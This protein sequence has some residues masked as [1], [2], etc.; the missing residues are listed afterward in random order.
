MNIQDEIQKTVGLLTDNT[1]KNNLFSKICRLQQQFNNSCKVY[2]SLEDGVR[3][4]ANVGKWVLGECV[5]VVPIDVIT[6]RFNIHC[7]VIENA[8]LED[9]YELVL[10]KGLIDNEIEIGRIRFNKSDKKGQGV[11]NINF[12]CKCLQANERISAKVASSSGNNGYVDI[13]LMYHDVY[14]ETGFEE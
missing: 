9:S 6:T 14:F 1:G 7:I 12:Q 10:F 8:S 4:F 13:S 3:V 5:E 11:S 2:P